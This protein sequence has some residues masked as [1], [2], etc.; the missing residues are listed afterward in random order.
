MHE[1]IE[2][3]VTNGFALSSKPVKF[4][5]PTDKLSIH[6]WIVNSGDLK[7]NDRTTEN[8]TIKPAESVFKESFSKFPM[9]ELSSQL[10]FD[11]DSVISNSGEKTLCPEIPII[12]L[13]G[14]TE[15]IIIHLLN[16]V[17]SFL[18]VVLIRK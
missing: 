18:T 3:L 4:T 16:K 1:Y 10:G 11:S 8:S 2:Y 15:K 6:K 5:P 7:P 14:Q 17:G 13:F 9:S 12:Y